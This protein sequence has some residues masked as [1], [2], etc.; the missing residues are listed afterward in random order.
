MKNTNAI[1]FSIFFHFFSKK[2]FKGTDKKLYQSTGIKQCKGFS[3]YLSMQRI[4]IAGAGIGSL[5]ASIRLAQVGFDVHV[6]EQKSEAGGKMTEIK[7]AGF[8]FDA[9]PSLFTMPLYVEKLLNNEIPFEYQKLDTLCHYFFSDGTFFACP[10]EPETF[11]SNASKHFN[12]DAKAIR[13]HLKHSEYL[14]KITAPVF[15]EKSLHRLSTYTHKYGLRGILNLPKIGINKSMHT[16]NCNRFRSKNLIQLFDRYATYNG[17][18]PWKA[19]ST[20]NVIPHLE[21]GIGAF[22]PKGGMVS[23]A[24]ALQK[25]ATQLGVTFHFN[26]FVSAIC[27]E[28]NKITGLIANGTMHPADLVLSNLDVRLTYKLLNLPLPVKIKK[29]EPS[30]SALIF[31]WGIRGQFPKLDLHNILFS[32]DYKREFQNIFENGSIDEDPTVY[33]NIS[34]K[35][36]PGDAPKDCENWFVMI[37]T[38]ANR[39]QNWEEL[40][41]QARKFIIQKINSALSC[42][43]EDRIEFEEY[44]DPV[45]IETLT[46]STFGSLYGSSSNNLMSAFFRQANFSSKIKGLYFCGGS[47]HPGGGIPL[48]ILGGNIASD[49]II[50]KHHAS[51]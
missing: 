35:F 42:N 19:P 49:I 18:N 13:K 7:G 39:G 46:G 25:R 11:I 5:A 47:V 29:S 3:G 16:A 48:C 12:D 2:Q 43:I 30:S 36:E 33:I 37:N 8:R 23:I 45:R 22:I 28:K 24:R 51:R 38:P 9:G 6:F 10:S 50:K 40:R 4:C 31:Y 26:Q 44:L 20:L 41:K 21:M 34:S 27:T 1:L 15:L 32:G 14:Y 17:S